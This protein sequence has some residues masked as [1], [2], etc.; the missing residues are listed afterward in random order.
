MQ[1]N[2]KAL[3]YARITVNS[4]R[5]N[6]SL[7]RK[8]YINDWDSKKSKVVNRQQKVDYFRP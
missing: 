1:K 6:I 8:V 2:E 5:V 4:K 3:L 7:K